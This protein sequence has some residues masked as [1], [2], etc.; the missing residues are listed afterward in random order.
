MRSLAVALLPVLCVCACGS[1]ASPSSGTATPDGGAPTEGGAAHA[2]VTVTPPTAHA[3]A[4]GTAQFQATVTGVAVTTVTWSVEE[5]AAGGTIA[6]TGQYTAPS[7][8]GAYHVVATSTADPSATGTAQV[9][10]TAPQPCAGTASSVGVWEEVSPPAFH[11]PSNM[12][13]WAVAV[14]PQ[15]ESVFAAA[16]NV[17]NGGN[18]GSGVYKSTDCGATWSLASTGSHGADL[19]TGDPWAIL[20]DPIDTATMYV[21][22]GYG[23]D[24]TLFQSTNGGVDWQPLDIDPC[25][26]TAPRFAQAVSIDPTDHLHIALTFHEDCAATGTKTCSVALPN[27]PMC[28]AQTKDGGHTW[29]Y[30]NGPT[31]AQGVKGWQE[32]ASLLVL[33]ADAYLLTTPGAG[34]WLTRDGGATWQSKIATGNMYGSYAGSVHL[35]SN[36]AL[37]AGVAND[38]I[39]ASTADATHALGDVWTRIPG[40]PMASVVYDDGVSLF[41]S[42]GWDTSG[43]PYWS[44]SLTT[45]AAWANMPAPTDPG[46]SNELAYDAAHHLLYSASIDA[47]LWRLRTR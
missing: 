1:S 32:A 9:T 35:A 12:Q 18:L 28:L 16:G 19:A 34:G 20:I 29:S 17:T 25:G 24:L 40:A 14:N 15:D 47:G 22:N 45:G 4:G 33:G 21:D 44:A 11:Q 43:H 30:V 8:A 3:L 2:A 46:P 31:V 13:T 6:S 41:A 10:V 38:G 23:D 26:V 27:T 5:G 36:G 37:Y 7:A 39:Y 42:W